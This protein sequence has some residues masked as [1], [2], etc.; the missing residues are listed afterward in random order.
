MSWIW[1]KLADHVGDHVVLSPEGVVLMTSPGT[2]SLKHSLAWS[3]QSGAGWNRVVIIWYYCIG[4][5][6]TSPQRMNPNEQRRCVSCVV[7]VRDV[8]LWVMFL[9]SWCPSHNGHKEQNPTRISCPESRAPPRMMGAER[10]LPANMPDTGLFASLPSSIT[11][12]VCLPS[13]VLFVVRTVL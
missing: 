6:R 8:W 7:S 3:F 12:Y 10:S 11:C 5:W 4:A 13:Q 2:E 9:A 1:G